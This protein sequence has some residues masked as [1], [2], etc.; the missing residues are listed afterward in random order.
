LWD[1]GDIVAYAALD[2]PTSMPE[3]VRLVPYWEAPSRHR[4]TIVMDDAGVD[5]YRS[6]SSE[7]DGCFDSV[8]EAMDGVAHSETEM[9]ELVP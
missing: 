1:G 9:I 5:V 2:E 4:P 3:A 6:D 7:D 8:L